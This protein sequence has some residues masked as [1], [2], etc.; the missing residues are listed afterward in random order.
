MKNL[1]LSLLLACFTYGLNAQGIQFFEGSWDQAVEKATKENKHIFVDA[2]AVWCGPCKWMNAN[3]FPEEEVGT[4]YNKN[5]VNVKL[6]MEKEGEGKD[7]ADKMKVRSYPTFL[8]FS[9]K[10]EPTHR[11]VGGRQTEEFVQLGADA[12][13]EQTQYY[14]IKK[15]Y[16]ANKDDPEWVL[17]YALAM[18]NAGESPKDVMEHFAELTNQDDWGMPHNWERIVQIEVPFTSPL[19]SYALKNEAELSKLVEQEWMFEAFK[20]YPQRS[21]IRQIVGETETEA[22][23]QPAFVTITEVLP[24][25]DSPAMVAKLHAE[26]YKRHQ[27]EDAWEKVCIYLD[28]FCESSN[29]LNSAA[30]KLAEDETADANKLHSGLMWVN[31]SIQLARSYGNLDTKAWILYRLGKMSE[32]ELAAN[33]AIEAAKAADQDYAGTTELLQLIHGS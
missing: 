24:Q 33:E 21:F 31:K 4:F 14:E 22:E 8:F 1:T 6:D 32:A 20:S 18:Q 3:I 30:W 19:Y 13:N 11:S 23:L 9:P 16:D 25:N 28:N 29:E 7:M 17:N 12:L 15:K 26:W 10:G 2:Y 5:F 27:P